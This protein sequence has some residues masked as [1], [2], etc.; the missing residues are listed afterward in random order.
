MARLDDDERPVF[1]VPFVQAVEGHYLNWGMDVVVRGGDP[2]ALGP[3]IE[4]AVRE[5]FPDAAVFNLASL[6]EVIEQSLASRRF[7]LL[8]LAAF[9]VVALVLSMV[10]VG[11]V[12]LL[13]VKQRTRELGVHLALGAVPGQLWWRIQR[14]GLGLVAGGALIGV[15]AAL[16][17]SSGFASLVYGVS[18]RDPIA[19]A[20]APGLLTIV[21]FLAALVPAARARRIDPLT[22]IRD[23][24]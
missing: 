20:A 4:G 1:Y 24:D 16:A 10:G 14:E 22:M 17:A 19:F 7:Q 13:A 9:G 23:S 11:S 3:A 2:K 5:A 15:A 12:L 8:V 18:V 21:G 6:S